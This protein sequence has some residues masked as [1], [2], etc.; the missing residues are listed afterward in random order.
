MRGTRSYRTDWPE[1]TMWM[2]YMALTVLFGV[3]AGIMFADGRWGFGLGYLGCAGL[4]TVAAFYA[5]D[6]I[7]IRRAQGMLKS[8]W[9]SERR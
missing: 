6:T 1:W 4:S 2:V 8:P 7:A 5:S 3:L 9:G